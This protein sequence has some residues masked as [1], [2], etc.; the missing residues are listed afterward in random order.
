MSG[1]ESVAPLKLIEFGVPKEQLA[2]I[3]TFM[4]P[5]SVAMPSLVSRW[6][7]GPSPL[8]IYLTGYKLRMLTVSLGALVVYAI[9]S[10]SPSSD[11]TISS[12]WYVAIVA[13]GILQTAV[14]S[15][16]FTAQ[17]AFHNSI[18][19]NMTSLGGTY[20]TLLNTFANMGGIWPSTLALYMADRTSLS[21]C[22]DD[23]NDA[24]VR[25]GSCDSL[26]DT[27]EA[28]KTCSTIVDGYFVVVAVGLVIGLIWY[29]MCG[30]MMLR[31]QRVSPVAWGQRAQRRDA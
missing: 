25:Y 5:I 12:G 31:L 29:V 20:M 22:G 4:T 17:M 16:M 13:V 10:S 2:L 30:P 23:E 27:V 21:R 24:S 8:N 19:R 7:V 1:S 14:S 15:T 11:G 26:A 6:I 9:S 28:C 3:G 18:A